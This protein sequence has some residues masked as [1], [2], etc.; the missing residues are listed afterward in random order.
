VGFLR[1]CPLI[2]L[3]EKRKRRKK[4]TSPAS[5]DK[6]HT[7]VKLNLV[8]VV[9]AVGPWDW[10]GRLMVFFFLAR[11]LLLLGVGAEYTHT[12]RAQH[13]SINRYTFYC[14][15]ACV[16]CLVRQPTSQQPSQKPHGQLDCC[17]FFQLSIATD[18][19]RQLTYIQ[20]FYDMLLAAIECI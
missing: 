10:K 13:R 6:Q 12:H 18:S 14:S 3:W 5:N 20:N 9:C 8:V 11:L 15:I 17:Y 2:L 16:M 4:G 7:P 19:T 1:G